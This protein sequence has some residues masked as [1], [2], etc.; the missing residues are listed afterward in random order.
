[1]AAEISTSRESQCELNCSLTRRRRNR[2]QDKRKNNKQ[3]KQELQKEEPENIPQSHKMFL[4]Q[5]AKLENEVIEMF[6][7]E[8]G[9][10]VTSLWN[11]NRNN[12]I[13]LS[14]KIGHAYVTIADETCI[15]KNL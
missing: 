1:L 13:H 8:K 9:E 14:F 3:I 5:G 10:G 15:P 12:F 7:R 6:L 11:K 2:P 4:F